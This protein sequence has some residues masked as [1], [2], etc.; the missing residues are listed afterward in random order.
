M[1]GV[2]WEAQLY[3]MDCKSWLV[4]NYTSIHSAKKQSKDVE[5]NVCDFDP[6]HVFK[7]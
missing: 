3:K 7:R 2:I 4:P 1:K 5:I 6:A